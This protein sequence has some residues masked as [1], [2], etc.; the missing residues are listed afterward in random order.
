MGAPMTHFDV[1]IVGMEFGMRMRD[2]LRI[3]CRP[4]TQGY[5]D[6][7]NGDQAMHRKRNRDSGQR[8]KPA[9]QWIGH[10]RAGMGKGKLCGKQ[11]W[12]VGGLGGAPQ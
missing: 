5:D 6:A 3:G 11:C 2:D 1:W 8:A 9:G 4:H 7:Q 10:E 12:A